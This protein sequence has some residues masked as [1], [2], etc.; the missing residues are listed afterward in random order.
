MSVEWVGK[1]AFLHCTVDPTTWGV[2]SYKKLYVV[3]QYIAYYLREKEYSNMYVL[4]PDNNEK[5]FKF[6]LMFGFTLVQIIGDH[7]LMSRNT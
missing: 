3:L 6:S 4:I 7:I 1:E 5:L 2:K